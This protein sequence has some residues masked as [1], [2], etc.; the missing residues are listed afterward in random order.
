LTNGNVI[1]TR[2]FSYYDATKTAELYNSSAEIFITTDNMNDIQYL[3]KPFVSTNGK[4]SVI[5][6]NNGTPF[7]NVE[8]H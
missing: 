6:K 2:R 8:P 5:G 1:V 3:C 7:N 4:V